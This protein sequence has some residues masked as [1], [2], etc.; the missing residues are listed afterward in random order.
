MKLMNMMKT[1]ETPWKIMKK[2]IRHEESPTFQMF[3]RNFSKSR[4]LATSSY[5]KSRGVGAG[6][7]G[8]GSPPHLQTLGECDGCQGRF[9]ARLLDT[10][11][12]HVQKKQGL[13]GGGRGGGGGQ[14]CMRSPPSASSAVEAPAKRSRKSLGCLLLGGTVSSCLKDVDGDLA[15]ESAGCVVAVA[16]AACAGN[17][18]QRCVNLQLGSL[19]LVRLK[20]MQGVLLPCFSC[21]CWPRACR[22]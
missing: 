21:K 6:G 18:A 13:A 2:H 7:G 14:G 20:R 1:D 4:I 15:R 3:C 16:M 12:A 9:S 17:A 8:G 11:P 5:L 10:I 22:L 19:Q